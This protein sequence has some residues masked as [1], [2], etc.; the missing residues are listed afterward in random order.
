MPKQWG[1]KWKGGRWFWKGRRQVFVIERMRGGKPYSLTVEAKNE[2]DAEAELI[3]FDTNPEAYAE[4]VRSAAQ[5]APTAHPLYIAEDTIQTVLDAQ[6]ATKQSKDHVYATG[7]YLTQWGTKFVGRDLNTVTTAECGAHLEVWGPV[8]RK[9][10][11]T[12]LKT[13]CTYYA[14]PERGRLDRTKNPAAGLRVPKSLAAKFTA[15]RHYTM[16]EVQTAYR[17]ASSQVQRDIMRLALFTGMHTTEIERFAE[18]VGRIV[19]VDPEIGNGI[20][21]VVWVL[22]KSGEEHPNSVDAATLA[23]A[24]RIRDR[25]S[26]PNKIKRN[27][28]C[29]RLAKRI[30]ARRPV[31]YGA[32]RHSFITWA[33]S[34]GGKL[35]KPKDFG[36]S[37]E[38]IAQVV[39]HK[40]SKTTAKY[41]GT[42][43]PPMIWTP[44]KL[45]HPEDP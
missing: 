45:H 21:G 35:I 30:E 19:D 12:A 5:P 2:P 33:R 13:F 1:G 24:Q 26:I 16:E 6:K 43:V 39:G 20:V 37:L 41:D 3:A 25:G 40:N 8:A 10:R 36:L 23:A 15:P 18:G 9:L 32:L 22:H 14:H 38:E 42:E 44:V 31:L 34:K 7:L 29:H 27:E 4:R 11:I 17:A 28:F